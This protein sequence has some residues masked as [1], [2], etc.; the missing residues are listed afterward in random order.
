MPQPVRTETVRPSRRAK[1]NWIRLRAIVLTI[2]HPKRS[3]RV[4]G[5]ERKHICERILKI[6]LRSAPVSAAYGQ[7]SKLGCGRAN[8]VYEVRGQTG[9][10]PDPQRTSGQYGC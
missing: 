2:C 7:G 1:L 3:R 4:T 5:I 9:F 10:R 6:H 8:A